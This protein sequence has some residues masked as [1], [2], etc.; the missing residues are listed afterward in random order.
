MVG[1]REIEREIEREDTEKDL[2]VEDGR[3][4]TNA[5]ERGKIEKEIEVEEAGGVHVLLLLEGEG[6][7][8]PHLEIAMGM[9]LPLL[10]PIFSYLNFFLLL[11]KVSFCPH[12]SL[13][14]SIF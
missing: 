5:I 11:R 2:R 7:V 9:P 6:A 10:S 8:D 14:A 1:E 3:E 4:K 13:F 12:S